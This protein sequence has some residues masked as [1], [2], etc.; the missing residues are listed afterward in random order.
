MSY[1][2]VVLR[3]LRIVLEWEAGISSF[4][5][6]LVIMPNTAQ[7]R[8]SEN[9]DLTVTPTYHQN[10]GENISSLLRGLYAKSLSGR[11]VESDVLIFRPSAD[12]SRAVIGAVVLVNPLPLY[13]LWTNVW[14]GKR[15]ACGH[16]PS[17]SFKTIGYQIQD[18]SKNQVHNLHLESSPSLHLH[19]I[20]NQPPSNPIDEKLSKK[21]FEK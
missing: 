1:Q 17:L 10:Q 14:I 13:P 19:Q 16:S 6:V 5:K 3:C 21:L 7:S 8:L 12:H 11:H 20:L 9:H 18:R 15:I 2:L 4:F